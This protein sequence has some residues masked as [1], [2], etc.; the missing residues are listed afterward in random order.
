MQNLRLAVYQTI[1]LAY[2]IKNLEIIDLL[3]S[4]VYL[5][6]WSSV[7][8]NPVYPHVPLNMGEYDLMKID[9]TLVFL[10]KIMSAYASG[11]VNLIHKYNNHK[12]VI[13]LWFDQ[14]TEA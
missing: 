5:S 9:E 11:D 2:I 4:V 8:L 1:N 14:N 6:L 13:Y 3:K 10:P 7:F 12:T